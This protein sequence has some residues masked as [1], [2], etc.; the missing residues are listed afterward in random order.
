MLFLILY[1]SQIASALFS[2]VAAIFA[3]LCV[4]ICAVESATFIRIDGVFIREPAIPFFVFVENRSDLFI[5]Y[6]FIG[7]E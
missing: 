4:A 2:I 6:H 1:S 7:S 3:S 5:N